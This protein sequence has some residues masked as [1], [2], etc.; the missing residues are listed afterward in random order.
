MINQVSRLH[1]HATS[2]YTPAHIH[3]LMCHKQLQQLMTIDRQNIICDSRE[4]TE[5]AA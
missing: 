5:P 2:P 1:S 3:A 4:D